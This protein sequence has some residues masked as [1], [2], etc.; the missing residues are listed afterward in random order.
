V[1]DLSTDLPLLR[2]VLVVDDS[3]AQRHLLAVQLHRWGYA[4]TEAATGADALALCRG[5]DFDLVISDW[6][7]PGLTGPELCRAFRA[8]P[9]DGYGYFILLTSKSGQEAIATGLD[10]G[11]D[12]FLTKPVSAIELRARLRAGERILGMQAELLAKNRALRH[13]HDALEQDLSQ[14]RRLQQ[15][16]IRDRHRDYGAGAVSLMMRPSGHVGGDLVG[17]VDLMPGRVGLYAVDVAGHGVAAALMTARLAGLL[18][19]AAAERHIAFEIGRDGCRRILPPDEVAL[20]LNRL[21]ADEFGVEQY[22]TL[23]WADLDLATGDVALVQAG[24]PHPLIL[25]QSGRVEVVGQGGFPIGLLPE[26]T[27][28]PVAFTLEPGDRLLIPSDG[29]TECPGPHGDLGLA[30][31]ANLLQR[32]ADLDGRSALSALESALAAFAG[33]EFPDDLSA[34]LYDRRAR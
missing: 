7:M 31:L 20:R 16:L 25:R 10:G 32:T 9:R 12:D 33:A 14:A 2:R 22:F 11:A 19:S 8:L 6:M 3:R 29:L 26:A 4:V 15:S 17:M 1:R 18:S 28:Q 21:M 5:Q 30:G 23:I 34:I 24:H 13:I 27:W